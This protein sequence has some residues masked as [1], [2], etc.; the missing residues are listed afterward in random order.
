MRFQVRALPIRLLSFVT[1]LDM[2]CHWLRDWGLRNKKKSCIFFSLFARTDAE[3]SL[4]NFRSS[5]FEKHEKGCCF[6]PLQLAMNQRVIRCCKNRCLIERQ[7]GLTSHR[8]KAL[9]KHSSA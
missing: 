7:K 5:V 8:S 6:P 4:Y 2:Q 9:L 1:V 3:I